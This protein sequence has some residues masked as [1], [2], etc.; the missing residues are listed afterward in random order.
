MKAA[1]IMLATALAC[2]SIFCEP[3]AVL[4]I[5]PISDHPSKLASPGGMYNPATLSLRIDKREPLRWPHKESFKIEGLDSAARHLIV[6]ISD[7][8]PIQSFWFRFSQFE[9]T[10]LCMSFDG[11]QG[12]QLHDD[13]DSPQCK[14]R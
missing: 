3:G 10:T 12:V 6:V 2:A 4:C 14:C 11:Y 13:K 5:A 7:G 9:T 1:F 8:K